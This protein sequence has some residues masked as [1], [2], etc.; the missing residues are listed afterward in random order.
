M[1][2]DIAQKELYGRKRAV[3][4][5]FRKRGFFECFR[6]ER[7]AINRSSSDT[8]F[9]YSII[10]KIDFEKRYKRNRTHCIHFL[11]KMFFSSIE[12]STHAH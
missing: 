5:T 3:T 7:V 2:H 11:I 8:F 1:I 10:L 9:V 12:K 4:L 6:F